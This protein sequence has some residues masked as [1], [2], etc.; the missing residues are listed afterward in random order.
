M[1]TG[2]GQVIRKGNRYRSLLMD[3][4]SR[5]VPYENLNHKHCRVTKAHF[6]DYCYRMVEWSQLCEAL[7]NNTTL[8]DMCIDGSQLTGTGAMTHLARAMSKNRTLRSLNLECNLIQDISGLVQA[9]ALTQG[10]RTLGLSYNRIAD[11][12]PFALHPT[13]LVSL[14]LSNNR[15]ADVGPL[16]LALAGTTSLS[17]LDL[18]SNFIA[19]T[20]PLA[21]ALRT[22]GTLRT[23]DLCNNLVASTTP[24]AAALARNS[25]L[26]KLVLGGNLIVAVTRL[27][28]S[29]SRNRSL[30]HLDLSSNRIRTVPRL[31]EVLLANRTLR[32]VWLHDNRVTDVSGLVAVLP[33]CPYVFVSGP[34]HAGIAL[35]DA[36]ALPRVLFYTMVVLCS[37]RIPRIGHRS[38]LGSFPLD[39]LR[40][41]GRFLY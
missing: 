26:T 28:L 19:D 23:L 25:A 10:L 13:C 1:A 6:L 39:M 2:L 36:H 40:M 16:G 12:G 41:L 4:I 38:P 3:T 7:A 20:G 37:A 27:F 30:T 22:N 34:D 5:P 35:R 29:L 24:L 17:H 8:E 11:L 31:G 14:D 21:L 15:I 9:L 33:Y 32:E 18:S